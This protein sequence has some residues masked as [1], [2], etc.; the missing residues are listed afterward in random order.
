MKHVHLDT[1]SLVYYTNGN[2]EPFIE[3]M[4]SWLRQGWQ[5]FVSAM[6]WAEFLSGP[7]TQADQGLANTLLSDVLPVTREDAALAGELFQST[8]R[9]ARSLPDCVIAAIAIRSR[10]PLA[11]KNQS[12]FKVYV[13]H[14][15]ELL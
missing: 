7:L 1:N 14:G 2:D 15:L 4:D 9:R 3:R 12:D 10:V 11:T 6:V 5:F 8:G 13:Q